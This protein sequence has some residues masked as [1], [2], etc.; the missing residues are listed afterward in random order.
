MKG[1]RRTAG[2][3]LGEGQRQAALLV[4]PAGLQKAA[5]VPG[6]QCSPA[7]KLSLQGMTLTSCQ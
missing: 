7:Q 3:W 1:V 4:Q 2:S 6:L 5:A